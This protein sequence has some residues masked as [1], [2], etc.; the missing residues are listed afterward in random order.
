MNEK[1]E[2]EIANAERLEAELADL[3]DEELDIKLGQQKAAFERSQ[4]L[5][6]IRDSK[7]TKVYTAIGR[8]CISCNCAL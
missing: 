4:T 8:K 7:M 5:Q 6:T 2:A 3:L 1:Y